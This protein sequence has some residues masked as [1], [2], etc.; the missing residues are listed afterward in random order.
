MKRKPAAWEE[1][2]P[3]LIVLP[4]IRFARPELVEALIDLKPEGIKSE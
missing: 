3:G 1:A 4:C 2:A